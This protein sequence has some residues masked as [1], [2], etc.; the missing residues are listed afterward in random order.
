MSSKPIRLRQ[1]VLNTALAEL[2]SERY[3]EITP[4]RVLTGALK[5]KTMPDLLTRLNGLRVVMECEVGG[6][7][8]KTKALE[9]AKGRVDEGIAAVALALV[10]APDLAAQPSA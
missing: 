6:V 1:E 10:Y 3:P 4:E 8:A 9:S 2:I 5:S 7:G